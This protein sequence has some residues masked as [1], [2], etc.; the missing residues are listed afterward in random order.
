MAL[1]IPSKPDVESTKYS[2]LLG[3]DFSVDP[4][5]VDKRRSPMP[6]NMISAAGGNPEKRLGWRILHQLEEPIHNIWRTEIDGAHKLISHAGSKIYDI[7]DEEVTVLKENVNNGKGCAF[8]MRMSD[9]NKLF[10]LTGAEYLVYDGKTIK[11]V[12]EIAKVPTI[13]ISRNPTGGGTIYEPINLL[14]GKKKVSFLGNTTDKVFYLPD[15]DI[16]SIDEVQVMNNSGEMV[17]TTDYTA[18]LKKGTITFASVKEPPVT[19]QDNVIITYTDPT[20]GYY[21]RIAK[22]TIFSIYGYNALNRVFL[23]GNPTFK[24]YDWHSEINDPTYIPDNSYAVIGT[25]DTAIMGYCKLGEYQAIIKE[26]NQQDTTIFMRY[27]EHD[28]TNTAFPVKQGIVGVGAISKY[29][30]TNLGDEPLFFARTGIQAITSTLLNYER[31]VKNRSYFLD[32]KLTAE[33]GLDKAVACEWNG[34]Y[35]LAINDKCYILDSR[36]K[37]GSN[38]GNS[39]FSY[40]AYYWEDVPA[41]CFLSFDGELYFGTADGRVCK[42]NTDIKKMDRYSDGGTYDGNTITGGKAIYAQWSTPNDDDGGVHYYKSL[43][44]K[45]CCATLSPF[46]RSGGRVYYIVDG[47]PEK[48]VKEQHMD[49]FDWEDINFERMSFSTNESPQEIYFNKKQKKYK[50]LQIVI[51]ND[52]L[53]EAFG[54]HEIIKSYIIKGYSKNRR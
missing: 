28:G 11:E 15:T 12:S 14:S 44:K 26:D 8:S 41:V 31:V 23:S 48:F 29:C 54:I 1:K 43:Q 50:R 30:F 37:S 46:Q 13:L 18:D 22:C 51:V 34:Y 4:S 27:G 21:D 7:T 45:G 9:V 20:E 33:E 42:F 40:E 25:G 39:D 3:A 35:I 52:G 36:H 17:S 32:K 10:I 53:N 6:I 38:Q 24:A 2:E 16:K 47:D 5:L 19:G 49:L